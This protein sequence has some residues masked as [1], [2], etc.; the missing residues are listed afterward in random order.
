MNHNNPHTTK[1]DAEVYAEIAKLQRQA[2]SV[3]VIGEVAIAILLL[4]LLSSGVWL[5]PLVTK[6]FG[7]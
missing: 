1:I 2:A 6:L 3:K 4:A 7:E 5:S